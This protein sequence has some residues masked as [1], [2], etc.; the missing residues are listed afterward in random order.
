MGWRCRFSNCLF[1]ML[2]A[3]SSSGN[4]LSVLC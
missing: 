1:F 2:A 3:L 4:K